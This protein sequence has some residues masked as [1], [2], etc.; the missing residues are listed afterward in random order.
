VPVSDLPRAI[1]LESASN[2][3]DLGGWTTSDGRR[4]RSGRIFRSAALSRLSDA[5]RDRVRQLGLRTVCDLRGTSERAALPVEVEG[6]EVISLAIEPTV[7]A[8]LRD[9]LARR[10]AT[11][12][13]LMSLMRRA[14]V[15]YALDCTTQYRRLFELA[16]DADRLPLMFHCTAGKDRTG[17]AA[18]MLLTALGVPQTQ[19]MDDYL[20]T[21]RLWRREAA[22][23]FAWPPELADVLLRVHPELLHVAFEAIESS[24]GSVKVYLERALGLDAVARVQLQ[25]Q[26]LT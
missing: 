19:V 11:G 13:D 5:D 1:P 25:D 20:A 21:N 2:L 8:S 24:A 4:V 15:A 23:G 16:R 18:A 12:E 7:G 26:L 14:Y 9:I 17:F 22:R 6:V 3:R 10:D